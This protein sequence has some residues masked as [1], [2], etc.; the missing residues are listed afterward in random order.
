[1]KSRISY[2][3]CEFDPTTNKY[4]PTDK[5]ELIILLEPDNAAEEAL[6]AVLHDKGIE[7]KFKS[8]NSD[9]PQIQISILCIEKKNK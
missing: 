7:P 9:Y 8:Q 4:I 6:F 1:M 5:A 2:R 3:D